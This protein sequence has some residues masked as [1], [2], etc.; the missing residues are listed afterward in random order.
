MGACPSNE[1]LLLLAEYQTVTR[2][3]S[4]AVGELSRHRGVLPHDTYKK[5]CQL[6][7][8]L[9]T[10]CENTRAALEAFREK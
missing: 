4:W 3:Y 6:V 9:R 10:D 8:V 1:E 5:L 7:E 2:F